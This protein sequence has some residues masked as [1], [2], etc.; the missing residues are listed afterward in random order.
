MAWPW[1]ILNQMERVKAQHAEDEERFLKIQLVDQNSFLDLL[2]VLQV[3]I[4]KSRMQC[5]ALNRW[6]LWALELSHLCSF[7]DD[8]GWIIWLHKPWAS[9]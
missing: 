9:A 8:G 4:I 2:N 1:M 7:S 5:F 6:S 3:R